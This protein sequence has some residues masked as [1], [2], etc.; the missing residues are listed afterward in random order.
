MQCDMHGIPRC[1]M[2]KQALKD[3]VLPDSLHNSV[4][5][6]KFQFRNEESFKYKTFSGFIR[7][8]GS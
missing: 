3:K 5:C 6:T 1:T 7:R 4:K 2:Y 8:F